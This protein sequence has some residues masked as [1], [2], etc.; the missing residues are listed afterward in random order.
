MRSSRALEAVKVVEVA[1]TW[2]FNVPVAVPFAG[3]VIGA[4]AVHVTPAGRLAGR[5]TVTGEL[6]PLLD[7]TVIVDP[8]VAPVAEFNV[9]GVELT[10]KLALTAAVTL[11]AV[12]VTLVRPAA[13]AVS[14]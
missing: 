3:G 8:A 7:V 12:L 4:G 14:V 10:V 5:L 9:S 13:L 1:V 2:Q 11:K 6:N